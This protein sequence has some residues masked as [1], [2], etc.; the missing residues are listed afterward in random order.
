MSKSLCSCPETSSDKR[1]NGMRMK[2]W[3]R[4]NLL[5][6]QPKNEEKTIP[7]KFNI[8]TSYLPPAFLA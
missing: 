4:L 8:L 3:N 2:G 7:I 5:L 6:E 1:R